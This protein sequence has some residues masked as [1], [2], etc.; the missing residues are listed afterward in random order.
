MLY[1]E[2]APAALPLTNDKDESSK[3]ALK[4][5]LIEE[6]EVAAVVDDWRFD[7]VVYIWSKLRLNSKI[8]GSYPFL[9]IMYGLLY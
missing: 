6:E 4:N 2:I 7:L 1:R 3:L 5:T 8:E 9:E